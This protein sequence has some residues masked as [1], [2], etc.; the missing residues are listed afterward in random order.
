MLLRKNKRFFSHK[1]KVNNSDADPTN[2]GAIRRKANRDNNQR[3]NGAAKEVLALW[4]QVESKRVVKKDIVNNLDFYEYDE[5]VPITQEEINDITDKWLETIAAVILFGYYFS[6]Y[7]EQAYRTGTL[8][9]NA[10]I[11]AITAGVAAFVLIPNDA[12]L[13]TSEYRTALGLIKANDYRLFKNLSRT[14]SQQIFQVI[15]I[16]IDAGLS[17]TAIRREIVKR[18]EVSKSSAKRIT[19]TE[20][21]KAVNNARLDLVDTYAARGEKLGVMHI[22]A[23][24]TTTRP[25][26][27]ARH[28]KVYTTKAQ[29]RWWDS[30]HNRINCH[31]SVRSA[32]LNSKGQVEDK[33]RQ[34]RIIQQGKDFF[35]E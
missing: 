13:L 18:F 1:A 5:A 17:K 10:W 24:L 2:A 11:A 26:H 25:H 6:E 9:E 27:A 22:S 29:R 30:N 8:Q 32:V 4:S 7:D 33:A 3:L 31:C 28:G 16:G 21:N 14:T 15:Q 34:D 12:V 23:L 19:D 35:K 20:I